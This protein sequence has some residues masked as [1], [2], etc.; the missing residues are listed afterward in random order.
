[1]RKQIPRKP[2]RKLLDQ[3]EANKRL[4]VLLTV[5]VGKAVIIKQ[6]ESLTC[7]IFA[8]FINLK[9]AFPFT[10]TVVLCS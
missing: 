8:A 10:S 5:L 3:G 4:E 2:W 7:D 9:V 6:W 1:M